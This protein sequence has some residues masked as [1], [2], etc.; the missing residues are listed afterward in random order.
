MMSITFQTFQTMY[1]YTIFYFCIF[2]GV[3]LL[4]FKSSEVKYMTLKNLNEVLKIFTNQE[5]D[6]K[7][8]EKEEEEEE[9]DEY[10]GSSL[11]KK[12]ND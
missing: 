3:E 1:I 6:D 8:E 5:K 4:N 9:D 10:N 11:M 7:V 2:V 12:L